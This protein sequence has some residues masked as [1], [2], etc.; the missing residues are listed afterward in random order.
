MTNHPRRY[1][2]DMTT[3]EFAALDAEHVVAV[4]PV[5][6]I[7]Q[8]GPHLPV[9][10][11]A[12]LNKGVIERAVELMPD[13]LPATVLPM[14]PVGKSNEHI[15]FPGTLTLSA[16]TL[17]R[18]WTEIGASVARAGVRKIVIYNSHGGQRQITEV[19]ARELRVDHDM[20]AVAVNPG[21]LGRPAGLFPD[22]E[23]RHG[24]HGGSVETSMMLHL[25][26]DIVHMDK[27]DNFAPT[28]IQIEEEY[29]HI[30]ANGP[31]GFGWTAQ[32]LQDAGACGNAAD[33]DADRGGQVVEH[34]AT[35]LVELLQEVVRY[36]LEAIRD[37]G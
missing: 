17:I 33:A 7:E 8:H 2:Q 26:P 16:D 21:S 34:I 19:V 12:C 24:I 13:D 23:L 4:L 32:D 18:L 29:R 3:E 27:A 25:R 6:A 5:A 9:Y 14:M 1:W 11:D 37:V 20:F 10:V 31:V 15:K 35:A 36:P 28:T 22:L 30:R